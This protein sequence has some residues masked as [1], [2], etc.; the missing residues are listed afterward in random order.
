LATAPQ[1]SFFGILRSAIMFLGRH[2]LELILLALP[3]LFIIAA[4]AY[5]YDYPVTDPAAEFSFRIDKPSLLVILEWVLIAAIA[6]R[7]HRRVMIG[8]MESWRTYFPSFGRREAKF[9]SWELVAILQVFLIYVLFGA[10][11][12][13][14]FTLGITSLGLQDAIS[15]APHL[16]LLG[17]VII[18]IFGCLIGNF[19]IAS[20]FLMFPMISLDIEPSWRKA[21][22]LLR[23]HGVRAR[24]LLAISVS[25]FAVPSY[26]GDFRIEPTVGFKF[27]LFPDGSDIGITLINVVAVYGIKIL[28]AAFCATIFSLAYRNLTDLKHEEPVEPTPPSAPS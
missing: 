22:F 12:A 23:G 4:T 21:A 11:S 5:Y 19:T 8:P 9:L 20:I 27:S 16:T 17:L 10:G 24:L 28:V 1:F 26:I 15:V 25:V 2:A 6:V 13:I 14:C 7:W 18:A 3:A